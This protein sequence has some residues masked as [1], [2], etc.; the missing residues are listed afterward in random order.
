MELE[1]RRENARIRRVNIHS[2]YSRCAISVVAGAV[3]F[4]LSPVVPASDAKPSVG[5]KLV[6]EG[7][8]SPLN[9]VP[10][11]DGSGR[12]LIADQAGTVHL[13]DKDGKTSDQLFLDLRAKM[14]KLNDAFDERGLLGM[15]LHPQFHQNQKLYLYYSAPRRE[16]V[17]TNWDHTSHL[18]EFTAAKDLS[19]VDLAS[20]KLLLQI[21]K[22]QF[23]HNCGRMVFGPD[24]L[25]YVGV[26]DG[27]G[28]N[29]SDTGH[30]E[31]GNGQNTQTFL[32]KILRIDVDH[33]S[34]YSAPKDNPFADGKQGKPEIFAWGFRNPWGISFDRGG[35]RELFAADVG[36]NLYEELNIVVKGGNYGW[37]VRE[38]FHGF[39]PKSADR[40]PTNA[41][42]ADAAGRPFVDPV[43]EYRHPPRNKPPSAT[44]PQ[45][46]SVTGG[47]VYRGKAIPS[48]QARY[49]FADWSRNWAIA[50]GVLLVA[51]RLADGKAGRWSLEYLPLV[52]PAKLSAYIVAMGE[53]ADGEL[54]LMTNGSNALRGKS[55]KVF[56]LVPM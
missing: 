47:Y 28:A 7:F 49:V 40:S 39:D 51:S 14:V 5:L 37:R 22:P 44:E 55:G 19:K 32:G 34:P 1:H 45:G 13:L 48:L 10:L 26:G 3:A 21:D 36:Q 20:E 50:D 11:D 24:G 52:E 31:P 4:G 25:L 17:P 23:N 42:T 33:G 8:V 56:K 43:L 53:D 54:Y 29:D 41:P 18:S 2:F 27:G 16:S 38:G 46:I 12:V 6:A 9:F 35:S 15:A 30:P